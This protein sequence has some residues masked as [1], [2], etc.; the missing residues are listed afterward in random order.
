MK[1]KIPQSDGKHAKQKRAD[2]TTME[3]ADTKTEVLRDG[4]KE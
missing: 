4:P 2:L 1:G 3:E